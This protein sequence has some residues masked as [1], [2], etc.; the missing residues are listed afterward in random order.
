MEG[1][2]T[3]AGA[4]FAGAA[5]FAGSADGRAARGASVAA[6]VEGGGARCPQMPLTFLRSGDA[7]RVAKVRG[8][9]EVHHHLE[10]LG[11]V[12]GAA[13]RVVSEQAGNYIVEVKGAQ[14]ALD[15]SVASKI[16]TA[17]A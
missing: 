4:G 2:M 6:P 5:E 10:N 11:F 12:E 9:G 7:A 17:A 14:V 13:V 15:R 1:V 8:R 16:I 3:M